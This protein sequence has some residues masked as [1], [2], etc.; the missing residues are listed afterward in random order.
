MQ[1]YTR[2][3]SQPLPKKISITPRLDP[4]P[5]IPAPKK[6]SNL[7]E[8]Y[9]TPPENFTT[10]TLKIYDLPLIFLNPP[11]KFFNPT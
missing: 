8:N 1:Q 9:S 3:K 4:G 10:C 5:S 6:F 11:M 2:F 7:S